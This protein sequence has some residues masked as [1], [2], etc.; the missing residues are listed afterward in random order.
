MARVFGFTTEEMAYLSNEIPNRLGIT[1]EAA[2]RIESLREWIAIDPLRDKW[3][4]AAKS[5]EGLPRNASTHAAGVVF[6]AKTT[7]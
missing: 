7:C 5:L 6:I 1:L 2:F 3:F 4:Q